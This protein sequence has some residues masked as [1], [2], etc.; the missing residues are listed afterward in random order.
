[1]HAEYLRNAPPYSQLLTSGQIVLPSFTESAVVNVYHSSAALPFT[2][3]AMCSWRDDG[4]L[5]H[6]RLRDGIVRESCHVSLVDVPRSFHGQRYLKFFDYCQSHAALAI[7]LLREPHGA[8]DRDL[9]YVYATPRPHDFIHEGDRAFVLA[10]S[11]WF[12]D[13]DAPGGHG[14]DEDELEACVNAPVK[15]LSAVHLPKGAGSPKARRASAETLP[16]LPESP[17]LDGPAI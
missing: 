15:R 7:G 1:M 13:P 9:A 6:E 5:Y 12:G 11:V 16:V 10:T 8:T 3:H 2:L 14:A 17:E 4:L